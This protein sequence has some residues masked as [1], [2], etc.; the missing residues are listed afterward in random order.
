MIRSLSN[1]LEILV[2][3]NRRD[4]ASAG[5][6]STELSIPRATVYRILSTL[7]EK[8]FV[9]QHPDDQLF[10]MTPKVRVLSD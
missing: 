3:L 8:G 2:Y 6:L 7:V 10:H 9:Y 5:E 4:T 1:G